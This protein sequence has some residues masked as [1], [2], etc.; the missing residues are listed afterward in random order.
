MKLFRVLA[1]AAAPVLL[2][3]LVVGAFWGYDVWQD[4]KHFIS[5]LDETPVYAGEGNESCGGTKI[6]TLQKGTEL[7]VRRIRYWKNCATLDIRLSDGRHGYIVAGD[8]DTS[9]SP[10]LE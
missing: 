10:P 8:G 2:L 9:I 4:R 7:P 1:F 5:V 3:S 6:A